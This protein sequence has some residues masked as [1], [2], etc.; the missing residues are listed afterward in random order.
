MVAVALP[1]MCFNVPKISCQI[2]SRVHVLFSVNHRV[3]TTHVMQTAP[4]SCSVDTKDPAA[5]TVHHSK[6]LLLLSSADNRFVIDDSRSSSHVEGS[7]FPEVI[8]NHFLAEVGVVLCCSFCKAPAWGVQVVRAAFMLQ[9]SLI[10]RRSNVPSQM[11]HDS[12]G[13]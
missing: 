4:A 2:H 8:G 6:V 3:I 11:I 12:I 13:H 1:L 5:Y 7:N 9:Y 10:Q